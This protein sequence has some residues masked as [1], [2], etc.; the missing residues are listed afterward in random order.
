RW[1]VAHRAE[2]RHRLFSFL[3]VIG[4]FGSLAIE[5]DGDGSTVNAAGMNVRDTRSPYA[6]RHGAGYRAIYTLADLE[7]SR[8]IL[9]TGPSGHPLSPFY[10]NTLR[11]GRDVRYVRRARTRAEAEREAA[12]IIALNPLR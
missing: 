2:M 11:D 9:S 5:A 1:G 3:P 8:F 12:G 6:A 10:E 4:A 7:D